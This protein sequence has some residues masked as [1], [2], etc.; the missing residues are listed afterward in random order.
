MIQY[1]C[2]EVTDMKEWLETGIHQ[3][4]GLLSKDGEFQELSQ[5]LIVA[6]AGYQTVIDR[7][8]PKERQY[9]E[10]YIALCEETEYQKTLT[11]YYCGKRNG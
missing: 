10:N 2:L 3:V 1:F 9:I 6:Q 7:L 4:N 8:A 5:R 11:A